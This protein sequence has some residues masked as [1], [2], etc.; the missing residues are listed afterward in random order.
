MAFT[1]AQLR[2][3]IR[4]YTEVSDTVLTDSVVN[5]IIKNAENR[6]FRTVDSDDTK[7]YAT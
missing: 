6:I 7:F 4:N 3:A 5:D 1:L 2:T